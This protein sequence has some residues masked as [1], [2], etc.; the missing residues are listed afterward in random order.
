MIWVIRSL[1]SF[2]YALNSIWR[3]TWPH[4]AETAAQIMCFGAYLMRNV[5]AHI[6]ISDFD[7]WLSWYIWSH[8]YGLFWNVR[9]LYGTKARIIWS[10]IPLY[11][12][13]LLQFKITVLYLN[14]LKNVTNFCDAKLIIYIYIYIYMHMQCN[15]TATAKGK[16]LILLLALH[17]SFV[18][19][20]IQK[21]N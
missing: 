21:C 11:Y 15:V 8:Y 5:G 14:I 6:E 7:C 9:F 10:K 4:V 16:Q 20:V 17:A 18:D 12:K 13:I 1:T 19:W 3:L 2:S